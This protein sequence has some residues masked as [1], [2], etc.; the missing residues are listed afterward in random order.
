M[1]ARYTKDQQNK[2]QKQK[3]TPNKHHLLK[4]ST[5]CIIIIQVL[6]HADMQR[7]NIYYDPSSIYII[8]ISFYLET[9]IT[10]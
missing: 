7:R 9:D 2:K 4:C 1:Q 10:N 8:T 6:V 3:K 5:S